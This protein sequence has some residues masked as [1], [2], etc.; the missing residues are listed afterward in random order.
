[1]N[2]RYRD[3]DT[4]A[5]RRMDLGNKRRMEMSFIGNKRIIGFWG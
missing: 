1:M 3:E 2:S 5:E 4:K